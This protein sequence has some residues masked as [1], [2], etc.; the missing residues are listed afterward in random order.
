M[1]ERISNETLDFLIPLGHPRIMSAEPVVPDRRQ[2][3]RQETKE[4]VLDHA[5]EIM[6]EQG[7]AGLSVGEVARRMGIRPPSLYGYFPSKN[8]L[9]DAL[10]E[11]GA[12]MVLDHF[13][14]EAESLDVE[15]R[16][17]ADVLLQSA[18]VLRRL[19][20]R[21][22]GVHP[23]AVLAAGARLHA[24]GRGLRAG[25]R[26]GRAEPRLV[27]RA[28]RS[29]GSSAPTPTSTTSI[30]TGPCS[31]QASSASSC[32]TRPASRSPPAGSPRRCPT[33]WPCSPGTTAPTPTSMSTPTNHVTPKKEAR[34]VRNR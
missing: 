8:A 19:V 10:F 1:P 7:V 6:A 4:E 5:A 17:L 24:V 15:G 28:C 11:R 3:R 32:P 29:W 25:R 18:R 27:R 22:P 16:S 2:R 14:A 9:Y 33:S 23:A 12:R 26:A 31:R 34:R 21:A 20:D 30:A 13:R